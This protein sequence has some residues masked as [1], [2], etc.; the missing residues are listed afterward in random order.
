MPYFFDVVEIRE[1]DTQTQQEEIYKLLWSDA[2]IVQRCYFKHGHLIL[3][4]FRY[5]KG[6]P[7]RP[8]RVS[9]ELLA[10]ALQASK[11]SSAPS[12]DRP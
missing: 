5:R 12:D 2:W 8:P 6:S 3:I 9:D 11:D 1:L 4:L 10:R 7:D